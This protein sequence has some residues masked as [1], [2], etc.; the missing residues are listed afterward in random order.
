M[1][2]NDEYK[3]QYEN[4]T[5]ICFNAI[6]KKQNI[7]LIGDGPCGKSFMRNE[8]LNHHE[9]SYVAYCVNNNP[10]FYDEIKKT[11]DSGKNFWIESQNEKIDNKVLIKLIEQNYNLCIITLPL[12]YDIHNQ[13]NENSENI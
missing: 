4:A 1:T 11:I 13:Y 3:T 5:E 7:I 12:K 6:Q 8:L 10:W 2:S 9:S